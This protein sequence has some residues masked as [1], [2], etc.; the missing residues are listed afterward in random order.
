MTPAIWQIFSRSYDVLKLASVTVSAT[1]LIPPNTLH[2]RSV[3]TVPAGAVPEYGPSGELAGAGSVKIVS[4]L[5]VRV[6]DPSEVIAV[7]LA[8]LRS[9][10][11][12][13]SPVAPLPANVS[14]P[15]LIVIVPVP[16]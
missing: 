9:V 3:S 11:V 1:L 13:G 2:K 4:V 14:V 8:P 10:A 15:E 5:V 7:T 6:H 16:G 12:K